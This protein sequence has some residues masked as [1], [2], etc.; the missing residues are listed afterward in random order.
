MSKLKLKP[1]ELYCRQGEKYRFVG[2]VAVVPGMRI[3]GEVVKISMK[4]FKE[5]RGEE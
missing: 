2:G 5:L 3:G 4:E 1:V